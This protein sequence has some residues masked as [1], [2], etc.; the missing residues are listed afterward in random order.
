MFLILR[1]RVIHR[2]GGLEKYTIGAIR[3][4]MV[5]RRIGG[6]EIICFG[7]SVGRTGG[8]TLE[9][10]VQ[11]RPEAMQVVQMVSRTVRVAI[12]S[13]EIV[14]ADNLRVRASSLAVIWSLTQVW[15]KGAV[16]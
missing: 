12:L 8:T 3:S 13:A 4:I 14:M 6:L 11:F 16:R 1:I 15:L 2:I 9:S 7:S 10:A 5:I